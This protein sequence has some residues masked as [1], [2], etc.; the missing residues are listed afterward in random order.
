MRVYNKR[1][2][3]IVKLI[4]SLGEMIF[5]FI[6]K[7]RQIF[8]KKKIKKILIIRLDHLGDVVLTI[9]SINLLRKN[10]ELAQIDLLV[11]PWCK[12][13]ARQIKVINNLF[14]Y[15]APWF[16][17]RKNR[18]FKF[19]EYLWEYVK[20]LKRIRKNKYDLVID[21]RGDIRNALLIAYL[22]GIKYRIGN[23][24]RGGEYLLTHCLPDVYKHEVDFN[25]GLL[26]LIG[27]EGK[28]PDFTIEIP[29]EVKKSIKKILKQK[30]IKKND[31]V[32]GIHPG[33]NWSFRR[34]P[35]E[36]FAELANKLIEQKKAKIVIIGGKKEKSLADQVIKMI[37]KKENVVNMIGKTDLIE[38][39][40]LLENLDFLVG[41]DSGPIHLAK[42]VKTPVVALLGPGDSIRFCPYGQEN[43]IIY[44]KM[45]CS[46]CSQSKCIFSSPRCM[47]AIKV[48]EVLEAIEKIR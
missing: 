9:P 35:K 43:K 4:D 29:E 16:D 2:R 17:R 45:S 15:T 41:N 47:K 11:G 25:L 27:I 18:I 44:K 36:C 26:S 8:E 34:W 1:K 20:L 3:K 19:F 33:A 46:P 38:L 7:K 10:Y 37:N 31:L 48:S 40:A 14:I 28:N 21:F 22:G 6:P 5:F 32:V 24:R 42:I 30:K 23:D 12:E 13:I 39:M